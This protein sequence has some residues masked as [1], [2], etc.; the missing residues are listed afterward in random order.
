MK[1]ILGKMSKDMEKLVKG[2]LEAKFASVVE[3]IKQIIIDEYDKEL[4]DFVTDRKSKTNPALYREEFIE[5]LDNFDYLE[6]SSSGISLNVPS[7]ENFDFSGR[8]KVIENIINGI[9]GLYVEMNEEDY[10]SVFNKRPVNEDPIDE[11]V[12]PKERIYLVKY[13]SL[14]KKAEI[15]LKKRFVRY[16]FS[17]T[18]P[19]DILESAEDFVDENINGWINDAIEDA[20]KEFISRYKGANL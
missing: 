5:K 8:L 6:K 9:V 1:K 10:K 2:K 7:M 13:N 16:P 14:I 3:K 11:Y 4:I 17:N 12:P 18:T 20:R 19:I 15:D